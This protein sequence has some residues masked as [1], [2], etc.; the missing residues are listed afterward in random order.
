MLTLAFTVILKKVG[1][2]KVQTIKVVRE[3]TGLGLK[4]A[5]D[6]VDRAEIA[7]QTVKSNLLIDDAIKLCKELKQLENE[8]HM[9]K[10][11]STSSYADNFVTGRNDV[12]KVSGYSGTDYAQDSINYTRHSG[13]CPKCGGVNMMDISGKFSTK[14]SGI[15]G[16]KY[17]RQCNDCGMKW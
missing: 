16:K 17:E 6:I 2:Q 5:K 15:L 9:D 1:P 10:Q 13:R 11:N 3:A 12:T 14:L 8:I 7:P 4:D